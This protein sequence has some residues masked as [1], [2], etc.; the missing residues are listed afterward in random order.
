LGC[1]YHWRIL[2]LDKLTFVSNLISSLVWP[3]I[4]ISI[5]ILLRKPLRELI[6]DLGRRLRSIKFPG[7]EAEFSQELAEIKEAA[8]VANLPP[9]AGVPTGESLL[10]TIE[11]DTNQWARLVELSP[12]A[13]ISEAWRWVEN[14]MRETAKKLGIPQS[15][16]RSTIALIR[17]LGKRETLSS[18]TVAIISNLRGIRNTAVHG[19]EPEISR[20]DAIE[21]IS[22]VRRI[23]AAL[24]K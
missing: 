13:A 23:I 18:D 5:V 10:L 21:Y 17:A 7:G 8:D 4:V 2:A 22:L 20:S 16:T 19:I 11:E 24:R 9:V 1:D 3:L 15:D 12:R 14:A 6:H